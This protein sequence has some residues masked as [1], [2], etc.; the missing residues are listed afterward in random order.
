[1]QQSQVEFL[2]KKEEYRDSIEQ[3]GFDPEEEYASGIANNHPICPNAPRHEHSESEHNYDLAEIP[4]RVGSAYASKSAV[5]FARPNAHPKES[6][7]V[8]PRSM[9]YKGPGVVSHDSLPL[10]GDVSLSYG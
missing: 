9:L 8:P 2:R 10:S 4:S 1:M 3:F 5:G 7:D 6:Y